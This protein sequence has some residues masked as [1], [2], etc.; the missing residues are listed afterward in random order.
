MSLSQRMTMGVFLLGLLAA[1]AGP[2]PMDDGR[3]SIAGEQDERPA[4]VGANLDA[5]NFQEK[6]ALNMKRGGFVGMVLQDDALYALTEDHSLY[7]INLDTGV[8]NWKYTIGEPL[9]YPPVVYAYAA[10]PKGGITRF[11]EVLLLSGDRLRVLDK[12]LG[13]LLWSVDLAFST[14]SPPA[15]TSNRVVIG[16]W[17]DRVYA[18]TKDAPRGKV[19]QWLTGA[20]VVAPGIGYDPIYVAVSADG[21][22]YGFSQQAGDQRWK[23]MTKGPIVCGPVTAGDKLY[24]ASKDFSLYCIDLTEAELEWRFETGGPI[25]KSPVVIGDTVYVIPDNRILSAVQRTG[26]RRAD[27]GTSVPGDEMWKV[28]VGKANLDMPPRARILTRGR[29][30]TYVLTDDRKIIAVHQKSG[31]VRWAQ[32]YG[33]VDFFAVNPNNPASKNDVEKGRSGTIYV[34]LESGWFFALKEKSEY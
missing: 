21:G 28:Q 16:S 11:D 6:W 19:W 18:I 30:H 22:I 32:D 7:S 4:W 12:D 25:Q 23:I 33:R 2:E 9:S 14:S 8:V 31:E 27:V 1:C 3:A 15:A 20:D 5:M 10:D 29:D 26:S 24:V 34:G 17:D 13:E